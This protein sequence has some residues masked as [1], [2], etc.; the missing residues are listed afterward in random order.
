MH[1][2][3]ENGPHRAGRDDADHEAG[4][5]QEF[6][7]KPHPARR[8]MGHAR[9]LRRRRAE[10]NVAYEVQRI[11]DAEH[12]RQRGNIGQ[13]V[14]HER[15]VVEFD[16]LGEEHFLG[17]KAVQQRN[18][19]HR[20]GGDHR[21]RRRDRH[22]SPQAAQLPDI[23][24][25]ALVLDDARGHEQR[26]L[27]GR[28]IHDVKDRGD[29]RER[30]V[31]PRQQGDQS[32][33]ADGRIGEQA[34]EVLL[35]DR[36]EGAEHEGAEADGADEPEPFLGP[37]ERRPQANQQ[38]HPGFHQRGRMQIG[39]D[40]RRGRHSMR[41]PEV[42]RKLRALGESP[43]QDEDE[44]REIE[45]VRSDQV[46]GGQHLVEIVAADDVAQD[47]Y[48]GQQA[49]P[50]GSGDDQGH[51]RAVSRTGIVVPISDQ[52]EREQT[53]QFPEENELDEVARQDDPQHGAHERQK[54]REEAG[55]R[56]RR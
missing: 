51:A 37:P 53:G 5:H 32:E 10:E 48:P 9:Q 43:Q 46:A 40:R 28:V 21:E 47:Q 23:A 12:A 50:A 33:M 3:V 26:R 29:Q 30:S 41:Q 22:Q 18:A 36:E 54:K 56:I 42:E 20:G 8:L 16:R 49:K 6:H 45:P 1:R 14:V 7:G 27:E 55:H 17:Q 13:R 2:H 39:G 24:R 35:E 19:G 11:G 34:L 38:K 4:Q 31:E 44:R 52:Q 25:P 15:T